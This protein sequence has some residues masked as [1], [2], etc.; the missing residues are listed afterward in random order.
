MRLRK[1]RRVIYAIVLELGAVLA[2]LWV[3]KLKT[4]RPEMGRP[5]AET[6]TEK[7]VTLTIPWR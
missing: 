4:D 2:V 3:L 7:R 6:R 1:I 5:N